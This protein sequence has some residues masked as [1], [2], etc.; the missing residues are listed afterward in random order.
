MVNGGDTLTYSGGG[1]NSFTSSRTTFADGEGD[2]IVPG[3]DIRHTAGSERRHLPDI[4]DTSLLK[5]LGGCTVQDSV[6]RL[7]VRADGSV[8]RDPLA[9]RLN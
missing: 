8:Y 7:D 1:G 5:T 4:T 3:T 2:N 9:T 6:L